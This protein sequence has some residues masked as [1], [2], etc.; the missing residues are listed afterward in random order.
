[1][2]LA[3]VT[4]DG[5]TLIIFLNVDCQK[6]AVSIRYKGN[7]MCGG[8][9]LNSRYILTAAHCVNGVHAEDLHVVSGSIH[10]NDQTHSSAVKRVLIHEQY[11][12]KNDVPVNDVALLEGKTTLSTPDRDSNLDLPVIGG[13]VYCE[14]DGLEHAATEVGLDSVQNR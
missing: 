1:M 4:S 6:S 2:C 11:Y 14:N 8:S 3:A 7:H 13:L 10:L 12:V 5:Q 9:I